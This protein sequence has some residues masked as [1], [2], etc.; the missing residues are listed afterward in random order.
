[1]RASASL[2]TWFAPTSPNLVEKYPKRI[3]ASWRDCGG[4][5]RSLLTQS[6]MGGSVAIPNF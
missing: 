1:M 2:A 4:L 3:E 5:T 6:V